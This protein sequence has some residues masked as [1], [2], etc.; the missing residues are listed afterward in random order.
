MPGSD[1]S[2]TSKPFWPT[3]HI[4]VLAVTKPN[5]WGMNFHQLIFFSCWLPHILFLYLYLCPTFCLYFWLASSTLAAP[6]VPNALL[7]TILTRAPTS[8]HTMPYPQFCPFIHMTFVSQS[9]ILD[10]WPLASP[11]WICVTL[12][13]PLIGKCR[14]N[15]HPKCH[16]GVLQYILI[17][18]PMLWALVF[19]YIFCCIF[20]QWRLIITSTTSAMPHPPKAPPY[21]NIDMPS[22]IGFP[23]IDTHLHTQWY[24]PNTHPPYPVILPTVL[25][26]QPHMLC[27]ASLPNFTHLG[28]SGHPKSDS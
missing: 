11:F 21:P 28:G 5:Y 13:I 7:L 17:H 8:T 18:P 27:I 12:D 15:S 1:L 10:L 3:N 22:M 26:I 16:N 23:Q 9:S 6:H 24:H 25:F 19:L 14:S 4:I 2:F 20:R